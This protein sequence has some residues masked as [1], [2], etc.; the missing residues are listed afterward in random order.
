M[1]VA[2][3]LATGGFDRHLRRLRRTY[4][5]LISRITLAIGEHFPDGTRVT[6]PEGG[7]VVWVELPGRVDSLRLHEEAL[8]AGISIAPGPLFSASGRY[9]NFMRLNCA[10]PWSDRVHDALRRLGRLARR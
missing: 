10:V 4:R 8:E 1:A 6:R 2:E 9:S 5:D 3:Y 7:H